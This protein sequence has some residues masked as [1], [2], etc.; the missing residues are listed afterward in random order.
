MKIYKI[1][2]VMGK[3]VVYM[4]G[5][6]FRTLWN[7]PSFVSNEQK[8]RI[9]LQVELMKKMIEIRENQ[10]LSQ[11]QLAE[12]CGINQS[13]IARMEKMNHVPQVNTLLK[14]LTP[15]GYKLDIVPIAYSTDA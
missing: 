3:G 13:A 2:N 6:N 7:D 14:L 5:T 8:M 4:R 12:K 1:F 10:G 15:L 11:K 9:N